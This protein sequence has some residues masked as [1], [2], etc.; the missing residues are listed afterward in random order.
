MSEVDN[1]SR[2]IVKDRN[3][4][5]WEDFK[6]ILS[7]H[8]PADEQLKIADAI[9]Q[10]TRTLTRAVD[11]AMHE[12]DLA[13]EYRSRLIADAVTGKFDVREAA[14]RLPDMADEPEALEDV[15][16]LVDADGF[17]DNADFE[18]AAEAVEA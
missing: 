12:T 7:P 9:E 17:E 13:R 1:Y 11:V 3:R 16:E 2:G 15:A 14:A 10:H 18:A 8:P 6:Q 5:Y 4:L